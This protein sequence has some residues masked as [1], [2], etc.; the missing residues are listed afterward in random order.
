ME[1]KDR[2][3]VLVLTYPEKVVILLIRHVWHGILNALRFSFIAIRSTDAVSCIH[4]SRKL[5]CLSLDNYLPRTFQRSH[6][7][8]KLVVVAIIDYLSIPNR[9]ISLRIFA[10]KLSTRDK[11]FVLATQTPALQSAAITAVMFAVR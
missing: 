1:R 10:V 4:I 9:R 5:F 2:L 11:T 7:K 3:L 8:P 6:H